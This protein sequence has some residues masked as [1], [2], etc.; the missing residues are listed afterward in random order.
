MT[1]KDHSSPWVEIRK[2]H[3]LLDKLVQACSD[4]AVKSRGHFVVLTPKQSADNSILSPLQPIPLEWWHGCL[5]GGLGNIELHRES[6]TL[7][8]FVG[9][10]ENRTKE[11]VVRIEVWK[12][13]IDRIWGAGHYPI[14]AIPPAA[15]AP[16]PQLRR[17]SIADI[18]A[19][20]EQRYAEWPPIGEPWPTEKEDEADLKAH[21]GTP[22][23][24]A[25][26]QE[27]REKVRAKHVPSDLRHKRGPRGPRNRTG[28]DL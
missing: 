14:E 18:D 11:S 23:R 28:C 7:H 17:V 19:R 3:V 26:L 16:S 13:D 24:R 1:Q 21:F 27:A 12:A 20:L 25:Q 10:M 6:R 5:P 9:P 8:R 2:V 15:G 4:G 22:V